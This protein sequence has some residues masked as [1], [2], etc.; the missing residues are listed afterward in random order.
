MLMPAVCLKSS[1]PRCSE[2]PVPDDP[3]VSLPGLAFASAMKSL[4][5]LTGTVGFA[6]KMMSLVASEPTGEK[7]RMGSNGSFA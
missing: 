7:S 6:M 5:L 4:T 1:A 3:C 2:P